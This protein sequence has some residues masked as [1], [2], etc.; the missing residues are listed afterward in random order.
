MLAPQQGIFPSDRHT[1]NHPIQWKA[2]VE[3]RI[4]QGVQV[5]GFHHPMDHL[6]HVELLQWG[7]VCQG[8]AWGQWETSLLPKV[9]VVVPRWG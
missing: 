6:N 7:M 4:C 1:T 9:V 5:K 3:D 2:K 8:Q